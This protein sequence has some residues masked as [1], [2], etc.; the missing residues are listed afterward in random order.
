MKN[1]IYYC[2]SHTLIS[3]TGSCV[4]SWNWWFVW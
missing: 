2:K 4:H 3:D 1:H